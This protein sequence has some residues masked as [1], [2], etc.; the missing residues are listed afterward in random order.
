MR[1]IV[2]L[3]ADVVLLGVV[4]L[5][6]VAL[7]G[8]RSTD[9]QDDVPATV[10][11]VK[12]SASA[13]EADHNRTRKLGNPGSVQPGDL[14]QIA[15]GGDAFVFFADG[16]VSRLTGPAEL[17]LEQS[18]RVVKKPPILAGVLSKIRGSAPP[19]PAETKL[20]LKVK[21]LKGEAVIKASA[22]K[23]S[24][25]VVR[26]PGAVVSAS[27]G[28]FILTVPEKGDTSI[29][30]GQ[31]PVAVGMVASKDGSAVP[32]VIPSLDSKKGV[33][34]PL[35]PAGKADS[36]EISG[37][38]DKLEAAIP[39]LSGASGQTRVQG[40][41]FRQVSG[42]D[43]SYFVDDH[44]AAAAAPQPAR[45]AVTPATIEELVIVPGSATI[46]VTDRDIL[47]NLPANVPGNPSIHILSGG[48]A[49]IEVGG[50]RF[51]ATV[52]IVDGRLEIHGLPFDLNLAQLSTALAQ[53]LGTENQEL[54]PLLS[55]APE[56]GRATVT[57]LK[58]TLVTRTVVVDAIEEEIPVPPSLPHTAEYFTS[59]ATPREVSTE[60]KVVGS[61]VLLAAG[62]TIF[63]GIFAG[64][65]SSFVV[66]REEH[67]AG[68]LSRLVDRVKRLTGWGG[69]HWA[70]LSWVSGAHITRAILVMF[71]FGALYSFLANGSGLLGPSG[72]II[73]VTLSFTSG[74]FALYDPWVRAFFARRMK[75]A[76]K[77]AL[78]PGQILVGLLSVGAS[79]LFSFSPG[80]MLG[81]PG[82]LRMPQEGPTAEQKF[83]LNVLS[84]V[85]IALLGTVA[86][87]VVFFLPQLATLGSV[88]GFFRTAHGFTSGL[89][90]WCL[91]AFAMAVQRVFF[92][93]LPLPKSTGDEFLR[94][95]LIA[96]AIPFGVVAFVF[97]HTQLNKQRSFVDF[98]PQL[99]ATFAVVLVLGGAAQLY[100]MRQKAK[101]ASEP[102]HVA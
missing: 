54:P 26:A 33:L 93:L 92:G 23:S 43:I 97:I 67:M 72:L 19:P 27:V 57:Y 96:W 95:N 29:E 22:P 2:S 78:Y 63:A 21:L 36:A 46:T 90:D 69:I 5:G 71:V 3:L 49:E 1:R 14:L 80:L 6:L 35:I 86:W 88:Q 66:A 45:R 77:V 55:I 10:R 47:E 7:W 12:G 82:G 38:L 15:L 81:Q 65:A 50:L 102:K 13:M 89:Q 76:A 91:A 25:F 16:S 99:L 31:G 4:I 40:I 56:P 85:F 59:I 17:V 28:S 100:T 68:R 48:T 62:L 73:L 37:L 53:R 60:W 51:T 94:K 75:I 52:E 98:T 84:L 87:V 64:F 34:I 58:D 30:V 101:R 24:A 41:D 9:S 11:V 32:V 44:A 18:R 70:P 61:N 79:R 83:T 20:T 39:Q 74:F 8:F 42:G